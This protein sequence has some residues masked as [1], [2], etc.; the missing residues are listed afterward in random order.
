MQ[1]APWTSLLINGAYWSSEFPRLLNSSETRDLLA[2]QG[3][4]WGVTDISCDFHV[5]L[6]LSSIM[7]RRSSSSED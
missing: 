5:S 7:T 3:R 4:M 1:V 6:C 2:S